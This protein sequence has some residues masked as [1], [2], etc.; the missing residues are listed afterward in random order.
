MGFLAPST[1]INTDRR[2]YRI[3]LR[4]TERAH[5]ASVYPP[6]DQLVALRHQNAFA[7]LI[8]L[9]KNPRNGSADSSPTRRPRSGEIFRL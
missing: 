6:Q 8:M 2:T 9:T 5:V 3:E 7:N 4:S 1:V